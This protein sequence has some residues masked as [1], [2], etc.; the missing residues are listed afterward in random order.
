M[1]GH[2]KDNV[3]HKRRVSFEGSFRRPEVK[4]AA[5]TVSDEGRSTRDGQ[6]AR[7]VR[8]IKLKGLPFTLP[9]RSQLHRRPAHE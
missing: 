4:E 3:S 8:G 2:F 6:S 7:N 9:G 1:V 5:H